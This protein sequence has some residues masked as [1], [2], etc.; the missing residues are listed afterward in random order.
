MTTNSAPEP[1]QDHTA[2]WTGSQ[3]IIWGGESTNVVFND[4]GY[5]NPTANSWQSLTLSGAPEQRALHSAAWT[6]NEML[7]W[8]GGN[9]SHNLN[10]T[11]AYTLPQIMYLYQKQ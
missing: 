3:M 6:G 8:G 2:V 5:Y 1:R 7:I 9:A 10:D 4:G 11:A